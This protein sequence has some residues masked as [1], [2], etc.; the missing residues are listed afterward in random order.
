MREAWF[1][2]ILYCSYILLNLWNLGRLFCAVLYETQNNMWFV[3]LLF[4]F[5]TD[6]LLFTQIMIYLKS[7]YRCLNRTKKHPSNQ[8]DITLILYSS[9]SSSMLEWNKIPREIRNFE[10]IDVFKKRLL[11]STKCS[12]PNSIFDI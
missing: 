8:R 5:L 4:D 9:L 6:F 10:S 3:K 11:E 7:V 12:H 2:L 1:W